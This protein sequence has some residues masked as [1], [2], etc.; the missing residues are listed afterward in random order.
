LRNSP[1][2]DGGREKDAVTKPKKSIAILLLPPNKKSIVI[3][4]SFH[5]DRGMTTRRGNKA[6][7]NLDCQRISWHIQG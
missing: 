1:Q 4:P 5:G 3:W 2:D 6:F 7:V